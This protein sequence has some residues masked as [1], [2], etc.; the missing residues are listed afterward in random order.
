MCLEWEPGYGGATMIV[1][2]GLGGRIADEAGIPL[3]HDD[4]T[5]EP[6][7]FFDATGRNSLPEE[8]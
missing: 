1:L 7:G 8:I 3:G 5:D 6:L 2:E 4:F